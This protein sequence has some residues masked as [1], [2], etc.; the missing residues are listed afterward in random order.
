MNHFQFECKLQLS[1]DGETLIIHNNKMNTNP[2][3]IYEKTPADIIEM[4]KQMKEATLLGEEYKEPEKPYEYTYLQSSST[5]NIS[6]IQGIIYNGASSRFWIYRKHLI[7]LDYD[8]MKFDN[9]KPGVKCSYPF[10]SW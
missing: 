3:Y 2:I 5:C 9:Q 6:D 1:E 7:S 4:R 10:F 8:T